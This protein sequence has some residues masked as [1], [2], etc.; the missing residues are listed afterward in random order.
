MMSTLRVPDA[1]NLT[2]L[3]GRHAVEDLGREEQ[4]S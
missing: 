3:A 2:R 1:S 4:T